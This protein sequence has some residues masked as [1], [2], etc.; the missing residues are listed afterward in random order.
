MG[1]KSQ[2]P[3]H[4]L[5]QILS[6]IKHMFCVCK[7]NISERCFFYTHKT[8][9]YWKKKNPDNNQLCGVIYYFVY[10]PII[11]TLGASK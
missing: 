5:F 6:N 11:R 3:I 2:G 7:R 4:E 1:L 10:L 8:F 9:V